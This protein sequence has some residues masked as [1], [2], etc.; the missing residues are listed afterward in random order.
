MP[1]LLVGGVWGFKEG[2]TRPLGNKSSFKLRLNAV[3]NGCTRRGSFMGNSLGVL[4][5]SSFG[6]ADRSDLLQ[7]RQLVNGRGEGETRHAQLNGR[8][9][10]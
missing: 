5:E 10:D 4:G 9:G 8:R 2:W 7:P 6:L 1:G 3:L